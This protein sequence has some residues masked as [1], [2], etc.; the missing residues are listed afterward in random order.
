MAL[1]SRG[2][3]R[4]PAGAT[5][6]MMGSDPARCEL[7]IPGCPEISGQHVLVHVEDDQV[8]VSDVGSTNGTRIDGSPSRRGAVRPGKVMAM[9]GYGVVLV[10][11]QMNRWLEELNVYVGR[12]QHA[13]QLLALSPSRHLILIGERYTPLEEI[14][15]AAHHAVATDASPIVCVPVEHPSHTEA[16]VL[17]RAIN[18]RVFIDGRGTPRRSAAPIFSEEQLD[19]L[20]HPQQLTALTVGLRRP[21]DITLRLLERDPFVLNV[22]SIKHRIENGGLDDLIDA[23]YVKWEVPFRAKHWAGALR[24]RIAN[25]AWKKDHT[26]F[27]AVVVAVGRMWAGLDE[28]HAVEGLGATQT[29]KDWLTA[30]DLGWASARAGR[31][32]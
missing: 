32:R 14:A 26:Q 25:H 20:R 10:S 2:Y 13:S 19:R 16:R 29:V 12:T 7:V 18:G 24:D 3:Y 22:P 30:L 11:Q 4:I 17:E 8:Y 5:Q 1:T 9:A 28:H 23:L 27:T 15:R 21:A 31:P 6:F